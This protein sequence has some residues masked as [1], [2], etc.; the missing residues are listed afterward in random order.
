MAGEVVN[1]GLAVGV[2]ESATPTADAAK[3]REALVSIKAGIL[4]RRSENAWYITDSD[5]LEKINAA[6]A[7]PARNCDKSRDYILAALKREKNIDPLFT[8]RTVVDFMLAE[9]KEGGAK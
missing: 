9:A 8:V 5:I 6:L 1:N 3:M 7:A 4:K 2:A